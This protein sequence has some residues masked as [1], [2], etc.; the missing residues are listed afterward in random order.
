MD[1]KIIPLNSLELG[2]TVCTAKAGEL[3]ETCRRDAV[4]FAMVTGADV[5]FIHNDVTYIAEY[6]SLVGSVM[7][8]EV[9]VKP[10]G[11]TK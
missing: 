2:H 3:V 10:Q 6:S 7:P 11:K 8:K 9:P 4:A 5:H 1:I